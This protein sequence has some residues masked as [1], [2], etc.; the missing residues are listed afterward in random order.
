MKMN[1]YPIKRFILFGGNLELFNFAE[2]IIKR[3]Y[4]LYIF[5]EELHLQEKINTIGTLKENLDKE[6]ISHTSLKKL[7]VEELNL[8]ITTETIGFSLSAPWI[9]KKDVIDLFNNRLFNLHGSRLPKER[10]GGGY[11]WQILSQNRLGGLSIHRL[12]EGI[13]TGNIVLFMMIM[14]W[15][16]QK[17]FV[18]V[19][20]FIPRIPI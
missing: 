8:F 18:L 19:I 16:L 14:A 1:I 11:S 17:K 20:D 9:F 13:D 4:E 5:T 10:G 12:E 7:S 15:K 2:Y 3:N 6:S